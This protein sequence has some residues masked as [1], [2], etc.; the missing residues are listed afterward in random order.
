V[1]QVNSD[2]KVLRDWTK[3]SGTMLS[4]VPPQRSNCV[5]LYTYLI[6]PP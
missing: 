3:K 1:N 6:T 5:F 4:I 2:T